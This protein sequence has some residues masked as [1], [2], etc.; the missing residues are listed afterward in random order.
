MNKSIVIAIV[1]ILLFSS[2]GAV[3][4]LTRPDEEKIID[5]PMIIDEEGVWRGSF[6]F[7]EPFF[8]AAYGLTVVNVNEADFHSSGDGRPVIPV[9]LTSMTFPFGTRIRSV[10]YEHSS[11]QII[12]VPT[13]LSYGS[14]STK[15]KED[16][17]IY[18]SPS[19]YPDSIVTYHTGGGLSYGTRQTMLNIRVN[20]VQYLPLQ[21]QIHF[22]SHINVTVFYE[23]P[24]TP[25]L[26]D[27]DVYDLLII[28]PQKFSRGLQRLIDHKE[29]QN[30]RT[31]LMTT[32]DIYKTFT[33]RDEAEQIKYCI[34]NS[35]E[36]YGITNVLLVGGKDGQ[37]ATWNLPPRYSHVLIREG[38]Q[39]FI[40][41]S[42]LSDLYFADIYDSEGNFS[43]WDTNNNGVY[44]EY[45]GRIIDEMDLYPDVRLGRLPCRNRWQLRTVVDKIIN[46]ETR[47]GGDWFKNIVLVAGDHWPDPDNEAE[48]ILIMEA[49]AEIM[50][51]FNPVK[52]Y[53][54]ET[55][56][57][58]VRDVN[59]AL[60]QGAGFAYFS[61]HG[62]TSAWGA[63]LPPDSTGWAPTLTRWLP[64]SWAIT[65][66]YRNRHM[67]Y[68]RNRNMLPITVVGGCFN[69]KFDATLFRD[70]ALS[71]WA[72]KLTS[73]R[74]GGGIATIANTGLGTH[75]KRDADNNG[76][77][78]YLELYDGWL[79]LRFFEL[80]QEENI[81]TVG[82][83][84]QEAI[85]Q[86]LNRFL[87]SYDEMDIKMAQQWQ[88][89]G[90]PSLQIS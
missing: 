62:S 86:Y 64:N 27:N 87:G 25:L 69:G 88:L 39:E 41:P 72:W 79:E 77:N 44:A 60:N 32:E 22:T 52:L 63:P 14:C 47:G 23:E 38:T 28:A 40:E 30:V 71:C 76:V 48:G 10:E 6:H 5:E 66:L 29:T 24:E 68:L 31:T 75:A 89:F 1:L 15:T 12:D 43:C 21:D 42:F 9:N 8:T 54:T 59:Q 49:A 70:G 58:T 74:G 7:S 18:E 35:I 37:T 84:H 4:L 11:S 13:M 53:V 51:D 17:T 55:G 82:E 56:D 2:I 36:E 33:G 78:D 80:Y 46:Y 20:P 65:S 34:K 19:L 57:L 61:G 85:T 73:V 81:R 50:H 3:L 67:N 26:Q 16:K 45:D 83:L 90:D